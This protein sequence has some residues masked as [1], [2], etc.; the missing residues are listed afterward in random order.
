[1]D[2]AEE[3][4]ERLLEVLKK[5][6]NAT[7]DDLMLLAGAFTV[8]DCTKL[9]EQQESDRLGRPIFKR[10]D[11]RDLMTS[12]GKLDGR[13]FGRVLMANRDKIKDGWCIKV[14]PSGRGVRKFRLVAPPDAT[15]AT[16]EED[17]PL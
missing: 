12:H 8:A 16:R 13:F 14:V 1:M 11:L 3:H 10:Q 2:P 9:A 17:Q 5:Y 7:I 6:R 4:L 15:P